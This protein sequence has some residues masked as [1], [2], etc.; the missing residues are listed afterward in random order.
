[1]VIRSPS[2]MCTLEL[3]SFDTWPDRSLT[4][5]RDQLAVRRNTC[6]SRFHSSDTQLN[7]WRKGSHISRRN[8]VSI[9]IFICSPNQRHRFKRFAETKIPTRSTCNP[10]SYTQCNAVIA[11]NSTL[12]KQLFMRWHVS[13]NMVH[14][15]RLSISPRLLPIPQMFQYSDD[16]HESWRR[17]QQQP[18]RIDLRQRPVDI[19]GLN[20]HAQETSNHINW[21]DFRV[22]W[23][24]KNPY[25]L[26]IKESLLIQAFQPELN[27]T[28]HSVP[29]I[30]FP[31]GLPRQ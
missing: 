8:Y 2:S 19:L 26:L 1:M 10:I 27:H 13:V 25:W 15:H 12:E 22:V 23:R 9:S 7:P 6:M 3:D 16:R 5:S 30:V 28:T 11:I 4:L 17:P 14:W 24:D 21:S 18:P 29:L 20:S 31:N